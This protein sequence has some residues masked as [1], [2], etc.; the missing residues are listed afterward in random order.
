MQE[1][2]YQGP[3]RPSQ[4]SL[5]PQD[6][7]YND[8][9]YSVVSETTYAG[10]ISQENISTLKNDII[11]KFKGLLENTQKNYAD[12]ISSITKNNS[13]GI[14]NIN[15]YINSFQIEEDPGLLAQFDLIKEG[16]KQIEAQ[17][18]ESNSRI[19][20]EIEKIMGKVAEIKGIKA[21]RRQIRRKTQLETIE[22]CYF[23][24]FKPKRAPVPCTCLIRQS[25]SKTRLRVL[26]DYKK[27][28]ITCNCKN[29]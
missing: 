16:V 1:R 6:P 25:K 4:N 26:D 3:F 10:G 11:D 13:E 17:S 22:P 19:K 7:R 2:F 15:K 21:V 9:C 20:E 29:N 27:G 12:I 5:H 28:I 8:D 23:R 14:Q 18:W 24:Q